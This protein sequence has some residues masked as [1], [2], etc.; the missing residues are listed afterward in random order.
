MK[1]SEGIL[2]QTLST[3]CSAK[4]HTAS[5]VAILNGIDAQ[6]TYHRK[7]SRDTQGTA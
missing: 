1:G 3:D 6:P 5:H 4:E 7:D 2:R